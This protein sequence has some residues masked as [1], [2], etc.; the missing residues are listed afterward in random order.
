MS[1][2]FAEKI[3]SV[4]VCAGP[5]WST[6]RYSP[7]EDRWF[8]DSRDMD[9]YMKK[10]KCALKPSPSR[11]KIGRVFKYNPETKKVEEVE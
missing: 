3:K 8:K 9:E 11:K 5:R 7:T 4:K 6:P 1:E 2:D 10:N